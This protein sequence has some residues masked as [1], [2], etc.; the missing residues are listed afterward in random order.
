MKAVLATVLS[1]I[2][3]LSGCAGLSRVNEYDGGEA[4]ARVKVGPRNYSLWLHPREEVIMVQRGFSAA[5]GQALGEGLLLN[6]VNLTEPMP[7]WKQAAETITKPLGCVVG[8]V[9]TLDNNITWEAA[10]SCPPV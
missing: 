3:L 10:Y 7:I 8:D 6:A 5:M 2:V 4:D 1:A 9:Y